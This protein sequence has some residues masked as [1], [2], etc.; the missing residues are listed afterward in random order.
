MLVRSR[1]SKL[2]SIVLLSG[3]FCVALSYPSAGQSSKA[4]VSTKATPLAQ[5]KDWFNKYDGLRRQAQ[6]NPK[7]REKADALLAK[8][9]A[10]VMP[11]PDKVESQGLF[12]TLESKNAQ[13]AEQLKN[14][15]LYP[16]TEQLHRGYYKFFSDTASLFTDYLKVQ[17]NLMAPD[18]LTGKPLM[19]QL[20]LRKKSLEELDAANKTLDLELRGKFQI[21]EY[22]YQ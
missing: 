22:R 6:M 19:G 11:G 17:N 16:E 3:T 10:I 14:L 4:G 20:L 7:E 13:A 21:P 18:P 5:I 15:P 8:G 2:V 9:L 12:Q 1:L